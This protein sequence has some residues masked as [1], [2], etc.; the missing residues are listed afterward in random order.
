MI[1]LSTIM[2]SLNFYSL[3]SN[4]NILDVIIMSWDI[5]WTLAKYSHSR[6]ALVLRCK[7]KYCTLTKCYLV[8]S[9]RYSVDIRWARVRVQF[10]A[11]LAWWVWIFV[12]VSGTISGQI[13]LYPNKIQPPAILRRGEPRV[14]RHPLDAPL[15]SVCRSNPPQR[16]ETLISPSLLIGCIQYKINLLELFSR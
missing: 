3:Y 1:W 11:R 5:V 7:L 13:L 12:G 15:A 10:L 16:G 2:K 14:Q 4:L 9:T 6:V 8:Y